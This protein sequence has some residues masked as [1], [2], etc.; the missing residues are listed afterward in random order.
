MPS[1]VSPSIDASL[2]NNLQGLLSANEPLDRELLR[3]YELE[4]IGPVVQALYSL[5]VAKD[6]LRLLAA[7]ATSEYANAD[8]MLLM[9]TIMFAISFADTLECFGERTVLHFLRSGV[10]QLPLVLNVLERRTLFAADRVA[11]EFVSQNEVVPLLLERVFEDS[12]AAQSVVRTISFVRGFSTRHPRECHFEMCEFLLGYA[13]S[14]IFDLE[15][16]FASYFSCLEIV[17]LLA[18]RPSWAPQLFLIDWSPIAGAEQNDSMITSASLSCDVLLPLVPLDWLRGL[19]DTI[20]QIIETG[21]PD[22][23]SQILYDFALADL[24]S[25]LCKGGFDT[26]EIAKLFIEKN[27]HKLTPELFL[28]CS[29]DIIT[30]KSAYFE[31]HFAKLSLYSTNIQS[32]ETLLHLVSNKEFFNMLTMTTLNA[33]TLKKLPQDRLFLV[34]RQI[35]LYDYAIE[36]LLQEMPSVV[37]TYLIPVDRAMVNLKVWKAKS[38]TLMNIVTERQVDLGVWEAELKK[39]LYEMQNGRRLHGVDPSV[40]VT[41]MTL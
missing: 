20:L 18:V 7:I 31:K 22:E 27:P 37:S 4:F 11:I 41:D 39:S 21:P 25:A 32:F 24:M 3:R 8:C 35:S 33:E 19:I 26:F 17:G 10:D 36:Y 13:K 29:P 28:R 12:D 2:L 16:L 30:D 40:E 34:L 6:I 23:A 38:D 9:E 5:N 1:A 14:H 15:T